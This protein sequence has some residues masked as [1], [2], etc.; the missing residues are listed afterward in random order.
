MLNSWSRRY[1]AANASR[2]WGGF[3]TCLHPRCTV[4]HH[5]VLRSCLW[6]TTRYRYFGV[7][8]AGY[9]EV[10]QTMSIT[11]EVDLTTIT[12]PATE[13]PSTPRSHTR[14]R[15]FGTAP[16][17]GSTTRS[18]NSFMTVPSDHAPT[19]P[20]HRVLRNKR[21]RDISTERA[22]GSSKKKRGD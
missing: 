20:S 15:S 19:S 18:N 8:Q 4:C 2:L 1:L 11:D 21:D 13:A 10:L 5:R 16:L 17:P 12:R 3:T 14:N 6:L 22:A 9:R 7:I